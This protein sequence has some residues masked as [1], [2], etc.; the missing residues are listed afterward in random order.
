MKL[1]KFIDNITFKGESYEFADKEARER[2]KS[3]EYQ[4]VTTDLA[5]SHKD[6]PEGEKTVTVQSDGV[7]GDTTIVGN[8]TNLVPNGGFNRALPYRGIMIANKGDGYVITGSTTTQSVTLYFTDNMGNYDIPVSADLIGKT[9]VHALFTDSEQGNASLSATFLDEN[10]AQLSKVGGVIKTAMR[11]IV[12]PEGTVYIRCM[13]YC[14][15]NIECNHEVKFYLIEKESFQS[16]TLN[17]G[18]SEI[19]GITEKVIHSVPY[20]STV[21]Y[22]IT[23]RKLI[24]DYAGDTATYLTP[25]AFGAVGDSSTD[26]STAITECLESASQTGKMVIMA[27]RYFITSPI[28]ITQSGLEIICND[29]VYNGTDCAVKIIGRENKIKIHSITSNSIGLSF[30]AIGQKSTSYNSVEVNTIASQSHGIAFITGT[31]FAHQ[32]TVKFE[33]IRAGG[34]G[35]YGICFLQPEGTS[36]FI[37]ECNLYGG[38]IANCEWAVYKVSGNSRCYGFEIEEEVQGGFFINAGIIIYHPRLAESQRDG[39]HP[40]F[41]FEDVTNVYIYLPSPICLDEI[42]L[43]DSRDTYA[44]D[45]G[46]IFPLTENSLGYIYGQIQMPHYETGVDVGTSLCYCTRAHLWGKHLIMTPHMAYRKAVTTERLDTRLLGG[47]VEDTGFTPTEL[48][49]LPTKFVVDTVNT[50]IYLHASYCAFGFNEFE[51][52]Q[53]NGF[54]CKI[55]DNL[56]NLIFDGTEQGNGLYK[57]NVYKDATYC[58]SRSGTLRVDFTGHY[59]SVTK[60]SISAT[61]DGQGNVTLTT[62]VISI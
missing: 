38:Q 61:D 18:V 6:L 21:S 30:E 14:Q 27:G 8:F 13:L 33:L 60:E 16:M 41:K 28:T 62:E 25:E 35:C 17:E 57:L 37:A 52:E 58:A 50:E 36:G 54:T 12:V 5:F 3:V 32:N 53:A 42:D 20:K 22:T 19:R 59:W 9:L 56:N 48:A 45:S 44:K 49:Q 23:L 29:I 43:S 34:S 46:Q 7:F 31:S 15:P 24:E 47:K 10:K 55:Y 40:F 26:D 1:S 39:S 11:E 51:V 2:L 4:T